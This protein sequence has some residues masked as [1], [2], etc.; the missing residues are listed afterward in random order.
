MEPKNN[1]VINITAI[2][3]CY[4]VDY[5]QKI[6]LIDIIKLFMKI[7]IKMKNIDFI[8]IYLYFHAFISRIDG[9]LMDQ[10]ILV[11]FFPCPLSEIKKIFV[12]LRNIL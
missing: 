10:H 11:C 2:N 8:Y 6:I 12:M 5:I 7:K 9:L 3:D 4:Y 1:S